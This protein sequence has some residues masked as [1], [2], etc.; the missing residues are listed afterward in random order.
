M[1]YRLRELEAE[2]KFGRTLTLDALGQVVLMSDIKAVI[3][4]EAV[5]E[6]R[7]RK[8]TMVVAVLLVITMNIYSRLSLGHVMQKLGQGL[9]FIWGDPDYRLPGDS[10]ISYRRYQ[11]G[12]RPVVA[13]FHRV[14]RPMTTLQTPG[15][16]LFGLRLMA[17]DGTIEDVPDTPENMAAFGRHHTDRGDSAF[18]Q[19]RGVYLAECGAHAIVD[20]GFWP[21]HTSERVGGFRVLGSVKPS[22]LVMWDRGFHDYD[23]I[24]AVRERGS[25]VLGRLPAHVQPK[26]VHT[27]PDGSYLAYLLPTEYQRRKRGEHLLVR[28]VEY[29]I[30]DP[31][32]P[33]YG[34]VHRLV[35]TL[36]DAEAYPALDLACAYHE[37][38]EIEL[39]IDEMDTH[40]RLAGRPL[41]SLKPVGVIQELYGLLIA[42]YAIRFLMHQA[43]LQLGLDPDRLSFVHALQVL[44]AAIPEF[45]MTTTEQLPQLYARLLRDIAAERLPARRQ[46]SNPRV[47]KRKMS[48]FHLKRSE[49]RDWP[50]SAQP[51]RQAVLILGSSSQTIS[52]FCLQLEVQHYTLA[53][54]QLLI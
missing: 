4:E 52:P 21:C 50:Q 22:M 44:H 10:A 25:H 36:L 12:A 19:V 49:H 23:M 47:V 1:G 26:R 9:R 11:L 18:P 43:A 24:M 42:Y 15:A 46:R 13:L 35:T 54:E 32:L 48:K 17:I 34:E 39:V 29:T 14:C 3:Q 41:R 33:G 7:E 45:Q 16:F 51:F 2:S 6:I 38:W 8:L 40:Q 31:A 27:L 53:L 28:I 30:T 5:E 20:A 37:R